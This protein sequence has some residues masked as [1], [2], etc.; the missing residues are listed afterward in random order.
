VVI[1]RIDDT[2]R[3]A[4]LA[5]FVT[6][7]P[8]GSRRTVGD[9]RQEK[10]QKDLSRYHEV[11]GIR[12]GVFYRDRAT[13]AQAPDGWYLPDTGPVRAAFDE[14]LLSRRKPRGTPHS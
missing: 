8:S 14:A 9:E 11:Y 10:L 5:Q 3:F 4:A 2:A 12:A 1:D 7:R 6:E 13:M